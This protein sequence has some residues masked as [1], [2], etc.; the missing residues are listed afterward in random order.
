MER[1]D[2]KTVVLAIA[3]L[4]VFCFL[5]FKTGKW[6]Y[7]TMMVLVGVMLGFI[8]PMPKNRK[9]YEVKEIKPYLCSECSGSGEKI[10]KD[11]YGCV[12]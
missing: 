2:V 1:E 6:E 3:L 4:V 5:W 7:G 8:V 11:L 12:C 10:G 9:K